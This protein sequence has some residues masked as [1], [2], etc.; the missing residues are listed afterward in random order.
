MMMQVGEVLQ[1]WSASVGLPASAPGRNAEIF[2]GFLL[3]AFLVSLAFRKITTTLLTWK[4]LALAPT[5]SRRA[6]EWVKSLDYS[7]HEVWGADGAGEEWVQ[8]RKDSIDRLAGFFRSHCAKSIAWGNEIRDSFSDLRFTDANR[9]PF[10]FMRMMREKFSLC[11]VVTESKGPKLRDLDGN[12]NI[13]VSGSYGLNLAG[14]DRYKEWMEK[15]LEKVK[16]LGP[17]LGP[18]HPVVS[19]NISI[20]KSISKLDEVS[21]HMSG[22]EAVMAAVKIGAV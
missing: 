16:D 9:V 10:P 14:F 8:R 13:D 21:F 17:V 2:L 19:E 3:S 22:T 5:L 7:E 15:G 18:L 4:A 11:S 6:S 20:L 12:W 1:K